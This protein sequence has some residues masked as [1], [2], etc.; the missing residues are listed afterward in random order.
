MIFGEDA[1]A[2]LCITGPNYRQGNMY[3]SP[4]PSGKTA[5]KRCLVTTPEGKRVYCKSL[6]YAARFIG[7]DP[8]GHTRSITNGIRARGFYQSREGFRIE[9]A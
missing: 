9:I 8:N 4:S 6:N 7:K 1:P 2:Y 3:D 5:P